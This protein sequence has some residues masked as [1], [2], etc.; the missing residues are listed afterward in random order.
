MLGGVWVSDSMLE[1]MVAGCRFLTQQLLTS[2]TVLCCS[3]SH[4]S[5]LADKDAPAVTSPSLTMPVCM[6]ACCVIR[7]LTILDRYCLRRLQATQ[8]CQLTAEDAST[9]STTPDEPTTTVVKGVG[10]AALFLEALLVGLMR[11]R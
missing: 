9:D 7:F 2:L 3:C 10:A 8:G 5:R 4:H 6:S 11:A 1:D